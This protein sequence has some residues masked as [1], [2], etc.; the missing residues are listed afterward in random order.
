MDDPIFFG[1]N[2]NPKP[3]HAGKPTTFGKRLHRESPLMLRFGSATV[4]TE[5]RVTVDVLRE[6]LATEPQLLGS[7]ALF[8]SLQG[9]MAT[10]N[11][12]L[13]IYVHGFNVGFKQGIR[14]AHRLASNLASR[15]D[16]APILALFSWPSNGSALAYWSDRRDAAASGPAL[17][18]AILKARDHLLRRDSAR[19]Q[20][21]IHVVTHSMGAYV[22][23][24][25]LRTIVA[26][27]GG[28]VPRIFDQVLLVAADEDEDAFE[29]DH[30][31]RRLPELARGVNVYF[32][33]QDFVLGI[34]EEGKHESP[35]LGDD[36]PR[37]PAQMPS[38]V[39]QIDCTPVVHGMFEHG[40]H[41]KAD[42]VL[43]DMCSV[44]RGAA[45]YT[46]DGR[47][48]LEENSYRLTSD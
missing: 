28:S 9:L 1:T 41:L 3:R 47:K 25:A 44:L 7:D 6:N 29:H 39:V 4:D 2:R 31:L 37:L 14:S 22:L 26:E 32:N 38:R 15:L 18:R 43:N 33:R 13:L 42:A 20:R 5:E 19:C 21:R 10:S 40:Y 8:P 34:S 35:R 27:C 12:D 30:K 46:M 23:R 36:G 16:S 17:G 11:R 24:H 45:P 48:R